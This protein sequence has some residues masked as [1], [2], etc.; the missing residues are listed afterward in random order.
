MKSVMFTLRLSFWDNLLN[1]CPWFD[2][3]ICCSVVFTLLELMYI[4]VQIGSWYIDF[5][6]DWLFLYSLLSSIIHRNTR[7]VIIGSRRSRIDYKHSLVPSSLVLIYSY[8]YRRCK[9]YR[10]IKYPKSLWDI[11]TTD[12]YI[13]FWDRITF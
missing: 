5:T 7:F 13:V 12:M 9:K 4:H 8:A 3:Y 6:T 11:I 1:I 2:G 10:R